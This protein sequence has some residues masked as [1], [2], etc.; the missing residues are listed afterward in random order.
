MYTRA[1]MTTGL[2]GTVYT[3]GMGWETRWP[4]AA[5]GHLTDTH[6]GQRCTLYGYHMAHT[7]RH[8]GT[9]REASHGGATSVE[10]AGFDAP[11]APAHI[12][13]STSKPQQDTC[14]C[15]C[16]VAMGMSPMVPPSRI[17][18]PERLMRVEHN[19]QDMINMSAHACYSD[20]RIESCPDRSRRQTSS[21][22]LDG[23]L[24][25]KS[26]TLVSRQP[27]RGMTEWARVLSPPPTWAL[28]LPQPRAA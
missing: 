11:A 20:E 3:R 4:L 25:G 9:S 10:A 26:R 6:G 27:E 5:V 12:Q 21:N 13:T 14:P 15:K 1:Q 23:K 16:R 8:H 22:A 18:H 17:A 24:L 28:P 19:W 7:E 2:P